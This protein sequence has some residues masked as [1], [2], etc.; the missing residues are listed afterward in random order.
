M[1]VINAL[2]WRYAVKTFSPEKLLSEQVQ[3]L[4][5]VVRLSPSSYGLQ[6]YKVIV[7]ESESMK[8]KLSPCVYDQPQVSTCSHLLVFA[9]RTDIGTHLVNDY[10]AR[11]TAV[12][13]ASSDSLAKYA[14]VM[15]NA[16]NI[17]NSEQAMKWAQQQTYVALGNML[18][19]AAVLQIDSCPLAGF[20]STAVDKVLGISELSLTS[21]MLCALGYRNINDPQ[22]KRKKVRLSTEDLVLRM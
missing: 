21:T 14:V 16:I 20:D 11:A 8:Q 17:M 18:T 15:K 9:A 5:E 13:A 7:I 4:L 19:A 12:D 22:G 10:V 2:N 3:Q 6:P 1:N